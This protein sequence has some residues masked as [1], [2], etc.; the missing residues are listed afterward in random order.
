MHD[1]WPVPDLVA[2]VE[3]LR[4]VGQLLAYTKI[5]LLSDTQRGI[6]NSLLDFKDGCYGW[7][8]NHP[9]PFDYTVRGAGYLPATAKASPLQQSCRRPFYIA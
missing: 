8:R 2:A 3:T 4:E 7:Q 5:P 9:R 1:H 6:L